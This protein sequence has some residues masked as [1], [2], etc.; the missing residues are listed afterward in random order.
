MCGIKKH[1]KRSVNHL[2]YLF[3]STTYF[4]LPIC[5]RRPSLL[6]IINVCDVLVR[7]CRWHF[8][9]STHIRVHLSAIKC[10]VL[11]PFVSSFSMLFLSVRCLT[12]FFHRIHFVISDSVSP[13]LIFATLNRSIVDVELVLVFVSA[14][15]LPFDRLR[16]VHNSI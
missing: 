16:G 7:I 5:L 2:L 4:F 1:I 8:Y 9:V 10:P 6:N 11:Y 14:S 3:L 15:I 13:T 12:A